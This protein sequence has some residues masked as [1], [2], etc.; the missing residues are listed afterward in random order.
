[1]LLCQAVVQVSDEVYIGNDPMDFEETYKNNYRSR[2]VPARAPYEPT[3]P[4]FAPG[5][6]GSQPAVP[7]FAPDWNSFQ[8]GALP[9]ASPPSAVNTGGPRPPPPPPPDGPPIKK[10]RPRAVRAQARLRERLERVQRR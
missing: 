5:W 7:Q 1:V 8:T 6:R 4:E 9:K 2:S 3:Q 10:V